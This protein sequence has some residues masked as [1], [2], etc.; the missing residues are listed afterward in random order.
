M[1]KVQFQNICKSFGDF[2]ANQDISFS[3]TAGSIHAL[4]GENGAG[5]STLMKILFGLYTQDSGRILIDGKNVEIQNPQQAKALGLGMVHQ[6][7]MLAEP[8]SALDN[9]LL[10]SFKDKLPWWQKLPRQKVLIELEQICEKNGLTIPWQEKIEN[11]PVGVQ[12]RVEIV[13][14]LFEKAQVLILDEPTA[15]LTPQEIEKL[16]EQ[17]RHLKQQGHTIL[18][19]T[20]KL[21]EVMQLCDKVTVLRQGQC[22]GT[23]PVQD[24]TPMSL[25]QH[26][27]GHALDLQH[28]LPYQ[29]GS[30]KIL[31]IQHLHDDKI[32][33]DISMHIHRGEIVGLAGIEGHG[34]SSLL[35]ALI[36]P[37]G[38]K[39]RGKIFFRNQEIQN[40]STSE[41][42]DLGLRSLP[43]DRLKQGL[44]LQ[45]NSLQNFLLGNDRRPQIGAG[46]FLKWN[47]IQKKVEQLFQD[48][49][50]RPRNLEM[51][52]QKFSGGNQQKFV[53]ARELDSQP[54]LLIAAHPTRGVDIGAIQFI[55][56]KL[57][58]QRDKNGAVFVVS[59]ELDE[60]FKLCDRLYVIY[61][62]QIVGHFLKPDFDEHKVGALMLGVLE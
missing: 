62:G 50:V 40:R 52:L 20:H 55:H 48:Y 45:Q 38:G 59:S 36:H 27:V 18:I 24:C 6:H 9:V 49:D 2:H 19:I 37:S 33:K 30:E 57:Q 61:Q 58:Q 11:L 21:K 46:L 25:A 53:V 51:P 34:Q 39:V 32:L 16:F 56:D 5:K 60:L 22:V 14:L 42:H 10:S 23:F 15:V 12:Q 44:L 35:Q 43:E 13:K 41:I 26:M 4:I 17:L 54:E 7:F 47:R 3:V 29:K 8:V 1:E 31:D 28:R